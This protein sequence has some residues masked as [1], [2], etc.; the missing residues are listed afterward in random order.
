MSYYLYLVETKKEY[1]IHLINILTP[2]MYQG[3][4]SIY[5]DVNKINNK[6]E[7]KLFQNLLRQIPSWNDYIINKE[8][9]RILKEADKGDLIE[10]LLQAVIKSNIMIL[11][12]TPPEKKNK[13]RIKHDIT[14]NKFIHNAYIEIA[15]NIFQNPYLFY[16]KYTS[17][18]LKKNQREA[19][20]IIKNSIEQAIRK[21]LPMNFIL[22]NYTG[23][24]FS[25]H[26][27]DFYNSVPN[28]EVNKLKLMLK[29]DNKN[30]NKNE[31]SNSKNKGN[32]SNKEENVYKLV[33]S[34]SNA[35]DLIN[36]NL[37]NYNNKNNEDGENNEDDEDMSASYFKQIDKN[38]INTVYDNK[39]SLKINKIVE[40]PL[41]PSPYI[42]Y[43]DDMVYNSE[44][45]DNILK[46]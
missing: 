5:D 17:Y 7:L 18:E 2:M 26:S 33:K 31:K 40:E 24:T 12:N 30:D 36:I 29:N 43:N 39:K 16:N 14:I 4:Q 38:I 35:N 32:S 8:T 22:Q 28:D 21:I 23:N 25:N 46:K 42:S 15:R 13:L 9:S 3:I 1:T 37:N 45:F 11:T 19:N 6:D 44:Y 34:D 41:N 27:D 20:E 10:S